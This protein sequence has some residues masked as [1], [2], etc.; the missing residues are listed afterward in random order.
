MQQNDS[1]AILIPCYNESL[2][3]KK[4]I[5]DWKKALP[6]A[7]IYVYDNNSTDGTAEIAKEAGAIVRYEYLQGKGNVVRRMFREIEADCY[8]MIDG[9]DT[10]PAK[11]GKE[12]VDLILNKKA[13]M[14]VGDRL[15]TT[16]FQ[17]NKRLFHNFGNNLVRTLINIFFHSDI[18]DVMTG[19]RAFSYEFVKTFPVTS[20]GFEIETEMTV[21][22]I[23]KNLKIDNVNV[24]Y[25][26]R[27]QGSESKLRTIPDGIKIIKTLLK[28]FKNYKPIAFFCTLTLI[29]A[30]VA[31]GLLI[32]TIINYISTGVFIWTIWTLLGSF[33]SIFS[34]QLLTTGIILNTISSKE[35]RE[36]ELR[37]Y[38]VAFRR[39]GRND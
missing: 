29:T 33:A 39:G 38:D 21:H 15:S 31:I 30:S 25:K 13:D 27:P 34:L 4:V 24:D 2:T 26:D 10:Y 28:M 14:V 35:R 36:F 12:M 9:D 37:L 7:S 22:A 23:H 3:I 6:E 19:C 18:K 5:E 1:I 11:H 17:Q 16:Y 20:K 8:I 32:P